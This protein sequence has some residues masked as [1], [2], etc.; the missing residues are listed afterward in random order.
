MNVN[1]T[2]PSFKKKFQRK[3]LLNI[4][5]W[6]FLGVAIACPIVNIWIG[7]PAWSVVALMSLYIIWKQILAIDLVEYNRISQFIKSVTYV[8]ILLALIDICIYPGWAIEVITFV[9][10][11]SIIVSGCLFF[12]DYKKQKQNLMPLIYLTILSIIG[13]VLGLV[14]YSDLRHWPFIVMGSVAVA[15]LISCIVILGKGFIKEFRCRFHIK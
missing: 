11:G 5:K 4:V 1:I 2:Y 12:T 8:V 13:S 7:G 3:K 15:L 10:F 14:L 6:P 9:V